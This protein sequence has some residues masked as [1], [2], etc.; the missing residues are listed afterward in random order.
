MTPYEME[1]EI[2]KL[3]AEIKEKQ[4]TLKKL[5]SEYEVAIYPIK[6]K[7]QLESYEVRFP[8]AIDRTLERLAMDTE[9][10]DDWVARTGL[11]RG[12]YKDYC[13]PTNY[14]YLKWL[15]ELD[16][17]RVQGTKAYGWYQGKGGLNHG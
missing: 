6:L 7:L 8:Y 11:H 13:T 15:I 17:P 2:G 9:T 3:T 1:S 10:I 14:P 12:F 16:D 5:K 4:T